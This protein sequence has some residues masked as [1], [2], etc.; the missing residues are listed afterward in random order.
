MIKVCLVVDGG[1][2]EI[3]GEGG[4]M[5]YVESEADA[6]S[7]GYMCIFLVSEK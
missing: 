5:V 7:C 3:G 1:K 2:V 4:L 6:S